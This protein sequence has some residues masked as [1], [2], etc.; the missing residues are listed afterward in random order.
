[1]QPPN[2][3]TR[4][5]WD[6]ASEPYAERIAPFTGL[7]V[8]ALI[9]RLEVD[10]NT[11]VLEVAAGPGTLTEKLAPEVDEILATDFSPRMIE[12]LRA[13]LES[14]NI[15]NVTCA[16]MDGQAL[17]VDDASFDRAVCNFG[18]MLFPDRACG[19]AELRRALRPE[20]RA[21]VSGWAG[22]DQFE[23]FGAFVGAVRQALPELPA[24]APPPIFSLAD[25]AQFTAEMESAGFDDVRIDFV[26]RHFE[27]ESFDEAWDM[28]AVGAPPARALF[29]RIGNEAVG[30][31]R[32]TLASNLAARFGDGPM[33]FRNVATVG[34]GVARS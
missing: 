16:V 14:R 4:E 30:K 12:L 9:E 10:S 2:P 24:A 31:L 7:Y 3:H 19:F 33:R 18:L 21:V 8:D 25:P 1:M 6:A 11:R 13:R 29:E 26:E 20:G 23:I 22:P 34:I 15:E 32:E 27:V 5:N 17:D 28:L